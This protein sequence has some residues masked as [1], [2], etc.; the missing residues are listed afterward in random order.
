MHSL[1]STKKKTVQ[2]KHEI[3]SGTRLAKKQSPS[4]ALVSKKNVSPY[5]KKLKRYTKQGV[6]SMLLSPLFHKAFTIGMI[7]LFSSGVLYA[8]YFYISKSFANEIVVSQSEIV[9]RVAELTTLPKEE[10]YDIV[11]VQDEESLRKQNPFYQDVKEGDYILMYKNTAVI[12]DL[13]RNVIVALK[14]TK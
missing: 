6:K 7:A 8:S 9:A 2:K 12:Y 4:R 3:V 5:V 14:R 11:R 10:P 1:S 13:R